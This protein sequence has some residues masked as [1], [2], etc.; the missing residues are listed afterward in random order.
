MTSN[1]Q[2]WSAFVQ[3]AR[4]YLAKGKLEEE[5]I[6]YKVAVGSELATAREAVL[7]GTPDWAKLLKDALKPNLVNFM[8]WRL[9][10]NLN[11]WCVEHPNTALQAMQ[12][13]WAQGDVPL[14]ERVRGFCRLMPRSVAPGPGTRMTVA[15][16]LLM[17]CGVTQYPPFMVRLFENTYMRTGY[18]QPRQDADEA[19]LYEHALGF[20]DHFIAEA[21]RRDVLLRHRLDAQSVVWALHRG[22]DRPNGPPPT[23]IV[24][25]TPPDLNALANKLYLTSEFLQEVNALLE[26][27]KQVIFQGPPGTGKIYAARAIARYLAMRE[28]RVTLVQFHPSYAYEDFIQGYRPTLRGGAAGFE[29]RDGPL[30]RA[31]GHARREPEA[32]H[33]LIIDEIN[34]GNLAKVF[35]ELYFLLEYRDEAMPLQYS[36]EEFSVPSNLYVIG[37]MNTADRSIALVDLALRRRFAFVRFDTG[38]E[39]VKGLLRRWLRANEPDM[40]WVADIVDQANAILDD[41]NAAVGPSYFMKEG[42][43]EERARRIW[44][45]DVLPYIEERLYGEHDRLGEF[46]FDVLRAKG[47]RTGGEQD[48]GQTEEQPGDG[49][50]A[51]D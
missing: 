24:D 37:T 13:I 38:E 23:P 26:E 5:E 2:G 36:D 20:L 14:S 21:K 18:G 17:G 31:A 7:A 27:K 44:K 11:Q 51:S 25:P 28:E 32:K 9:I 6:D 4:V 12:A 10:S 19:A 1:G 46:D 33:F 42:L 45:H 16:V 35:G 50:D 3:R 47:P 8:S 34:R 15:S 41:R 48:G 39:P 43:T 49:N 22:R 40:A 30:M 29:L